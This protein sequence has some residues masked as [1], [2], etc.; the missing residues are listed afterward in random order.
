MTN[1]TKT[2]EDIKR[3][4]RAELESIL[5][6]WE[7][8]GTNPY[9][10]FLLIDVLANDAFLAA[11]DACREKLM[12]EVRI[13]NLDL[14]DRESWEKGYNDSLVKSLAAIDSLRTVGGKEV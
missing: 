14:S 7:V 11:L 8:H 13:G 5:R 6:N 3:E 9:N 12:S 2:L 10:P 1:T 4:G